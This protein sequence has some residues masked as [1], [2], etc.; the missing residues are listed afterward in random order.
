MGFGGTF[1][2]MGIAFLFLGTLCMGGQVIHAVNPPDVGDVI[3]CN[4]VC[5]IV[6]KHIV[7]DGWGMY[8]YYVTCSNGI[9]YST[10]DYNN[11]INLPVNGSVWVRSSSIRMRSGLT[12]D[13]W[14]RVDYSTTNIQNACIITGGDVTK[15]KEEKSCL[16]NSKISDES[17][18]RIKSIPLSEPF[19]CFINQQ[20]GVPMLQ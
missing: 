8:D 11:Y 19:V 17:K 16:D 7:L 12:I 10:Y 15:R 5:N 18:A 3:N 9:T 4:E 20:I 14:L 1:Y 6:E 2:Y 13:S